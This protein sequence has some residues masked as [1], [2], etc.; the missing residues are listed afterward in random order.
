MIGLV[1]NFGL[2][3]LNFRLPYAYYLKSLGYE[4][5]AI[6]PEDSFVER[7][8]ES[9]LHVQ[10]YKL[11]KNSL[12]PISLFICV[13]QF[14]R[15]RKSFSINMVH[16][17]RLQPNIAACLAFA[18]SS[19]TQVVAHITG[20]GYAFSSRSI[21]SL[22]YRVAILFLYQIS[23]LFAHKIVVQNSS[24][25]KLLSRLLFIRPRLRLIESSGI[26]CI[27]FSRKN[28]E[29]HFVKSLK[30]R[31]EHAD[32]QK[33]VTFTGRLLREKGILEFLEAARRISDSGLSVKF[34]IAGWLDK[35][36]PSC[37]SQ[38]ELEE[39]LINKNIVYL[40]MIHEITE[41]LYLSDIFVLPTYREGFPRSVL[42]AMS[43]SLPVSTSNVPGA[44]D[45]VTHGDNGLLTE[46]RNTDSLINAIL[47]LL[48]NK[49]IATTM[50]SLGR[51][52]VEAMYKNEIIYN[53][54][55]QLYK[56][57]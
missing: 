36:N 55:V 48:N 47:Y 4:V 44:S 27:K 50:G 18:F 31:I 8:R 5:M 40:G 7:V 16:A 53:K 2:D 39:Y 9:G 24:D 12:D 34:V 56:I 30:R 19:K 3:F 38:T 46:P 25:F 29:P 51:N 15:M 33:V 54:F 22:F 49:E 32:G 13:R 20:L 6:L 21:K 26:D 11:K 14:K 42:E 1:E 23:L 41:L 37:I 28:A 52:R 35:N 57:N 10:T 17:F 45:A 43:M